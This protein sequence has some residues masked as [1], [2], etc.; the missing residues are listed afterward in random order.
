M[1]PIKPTWTKLLDHPLAPWLPSL[2]V[3]VALGLAAGS[4]A[5]SP[6]GFAPR[7]LVMAGL[8][9]AALAAA[10]YRLP[11]G[12]LPGA[13]TVSRGTLGHGTLGLGTLVL[14]AAL[15]L[16]GGVPAAVIAGA[17]AL[18]A[19]AGRDV[20]ERGGLGGRLAGGGPGPRLRGAAAVAGATLAAGAA[21]ARWV[22]PAP[23]LGLQALWPALAY[24]VLL[25]LFGGLASPRPL[26]LDAAGWAIGTL[27]FDVAVAGGWGRAG[28]LM[29]I[30]ALAAA[31]AARGAFLRGG[32]ALRLAGYERLR[33]AY[34]RIF[35]EISSM[36]EIAQQILTECRNVVPVEWFHFELLKATAG[37]AGE[38]PRRSWSAGPAGTLYEGEP[39]PPARPR[40]L[41]GVHRRA[42]WRVIEKVLEADG[43]ALAEVRLW[44]DPRRL[45]AGSEE[46]L[47]T[48]VPQMAS[49]VHRA[50]LDREAK[51]DA[52]TGVP[53]RRLLENR[54]QRL[55][56]QCCDEGRSMAVLL[57]DVDHFKRV[58]DT[59]GHAAGDEVLKLF[60]H[61]L[62]AHRRERDL[63]CRF[64]GEEF[65]LLLE[66]TTGEAALRLAERLR[67]AVAALAPE[68][69]GRRLSLTFSG[70]V[71]AFPELHV[72]TAG[73][74]LLL[75]DEAL[76]AAKEHGRNRCLLNLGRGAFRA[77]AG[78][79]LRTRETPAEPR[80]PR[81]F[82]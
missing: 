39:R 63:C 1:P 2:G 68:L 19:G 13:G 76:Y 44:C 10:L 38:P 74:L 60:A 28:A 29:A 57:C 6:G 15:F 80:L 53:V 46:L 20:A 30:V 23:V 58:N 71:A 21:A 77:P 8:F 22:E 72:K 48:L 31:E 45:E 18:A 81:V 79:T 12:D 26:A 32:A 17:A 25:L 69:E 41:P 5:L 35:A 11:A 70:G 3:A 7:P 33:H 47:A 40:A 14:P 82:D 4:P 37:Q 66:E 62:E 50:L 34:Q 42:R 27:L 16:L 49:S 51:L 64:G 67:L 61:T 65:A 43:D 56:R 78:E 9:A 59:Y 55:Y 36:G 54:L 75:A 73:E 52:L 24:V